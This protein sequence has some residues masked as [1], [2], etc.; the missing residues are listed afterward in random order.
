MIEK[1]TGITFKLFLFLF[2]LFFLPLNS[3]VETDKQA[4]LMVF[5]ALLF[6]LFSVKVIKN[7]K[8]HL[9]STPVDYLM[10]LLPLL[11]IISSL[12]FSP[13]RSDAFTLPLG[14]GTLVAAA[15]LF[16]ILTHDLISS[17]SLG[18]YLTPL[19]FSSAILAI[20][21]ILHQFKLL[22]SITPQGGLLGSTLFLLPV[23]VY[24]TLE[25]FSTKENRAKLL[26]FPKEILSLLSLIL[27]VTALTL[28]VY[29]LFTDQKVFLLPFQYG[30]VIMMEAFKNIATFLLGIGTANFPFAFTIGRPIAINLTPFWNIITATSSN[31]VLTLATET[32][33]LAAAIFILLTLKSFTFSKELPDQKVSKAVVLSLIT[34]FILQFI[35]PGN[36]T[37]F[38]LT[39]IL[40]ATAAP[41]IKKRIITLPSNPLPYLFPAVILILVA[42]Q[43]KAYLADVY[44]RRAI[45]AVNNQKT[46]EAFNFNQQAMNLNPGNDRYFSFSSNLSLAM[47]QNLSSDQKATESARQIQILT[48][49][50][51]ADAKRATEL[52]RLNPQ[53]WG[54]LAGVYK[55]LIGSV[56]GAE[57]LTL[58]ALNQ[59]MLLDQVSPGSRLTAG[60]LFMAFNQPEQAEQ[61]LVQAANLKP[62]WNAVHY[63][64]ASLYTKQQ[65]YPQAAGEL[66]RTLDLTAANSDDYKKIQAELEKVK[67]LLPKEG[68]P[69]ASSNVK[70]TSVPTPKA[71]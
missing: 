16:F 32:G 18:V 26:K 67:E 43:M 17:Q 35:F 36:M 60:N 4:I 20:V 46:N 6:I 53:N 64:L 57:Q 59:Q 63:S 39:V 50:A 28:S 58:D 34:A 10:I 22:V 3:A 9:T 27:V 69:S 2:P 41:K 49:Q 48:Q 19:M 45:S 12:L 65:K 56:Q 44:F 14:T 23:T 55:A 21:T 29:H 8:L 51:V 31:F 25:L 68:T 62:D 13:N 1:L 11:S 5:T 30:W 54:N 47:A 15:V 24:L 7:K 40:L 61:F 33:V 37:L 38:I 42:M 52:N 71:K 66:Q 70:P